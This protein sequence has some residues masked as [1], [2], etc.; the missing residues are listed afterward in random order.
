MHHLPIDDSHVPVDHFW[1]GHTGKVCERTPREQ[2]QPRW[3]QS[4]G[5]AAERAAVIEVWEQQGRERGST[6]ERGYLWDIPAGTWLQ[7][8]KNNPNA[9]KKNK[10]QNPRIQ[11]STGSRGL[12][13]SCPLKS[14]SQQIGKEFKELSRNCWF[15]GW[16]LRGLCQPK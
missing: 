7:C 14:T 15:D 13:T 16:T 1:A 6:G 11:E 10:K 12:D 3:L 9:R 2:P 8:S 5:W 4:P